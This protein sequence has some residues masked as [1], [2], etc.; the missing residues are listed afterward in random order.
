MQVQIIIALQKLVILA[1]CTTHGHSFLHHRI[2]K[3]TIA[4]CFFQQKIPTNLHVLAYM[5]L[6]FIVAPYFFVFTNHSSLV[7]VYIF[8]GLQKSH[9]QI[10]DRVF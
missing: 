2:T 1:R 6:N 5:S 3:V 4:I 7:P 9:M 10:S 8:S